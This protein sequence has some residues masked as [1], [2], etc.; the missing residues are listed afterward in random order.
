MNSSLN[1][2]GCLVIGE[3]AQAHDG[4][5]GAAHAYIDA[6]AS[7][8]AGAVKFQTHIAEAEGT[9]EEPWRVRF[10]KQDVTRRDYWRRTSFTAEQ[11]AGLKKH[12]DDRG[13]LFLSS[14]FSVEAAEM[15]YGLGMEVWKIASGELGNG[16]L[17]DYVLSTNLPVLLSSGMSDWEELD[18]AVARVQARGV[19]LTVMQCTSAYPCPPEKLGLNVLDEF[20]VRYGCP[21]GLSDHSG[22]IYAGLA[23]A[24]LGAS[25]VEVHVTFSRDCF[26]PD[27]PASVTVAELKQLTEGVRF[28]RTALDHPR[29]KNELALESAPLRSIFTKSVVVRR[30]LPAGHVLRAEDLNVKKPGTGIPASRF[31]EVVGRTLAS[32]VEVDQILS[33]ND[34]VQSVL[35]RV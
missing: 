32:P 11:W 28:I 15:L 14:P 25:V 19:P 26:G 35:E 22:N 12:A 21:V 16:P 8:G 34:L 13:L 23:A 17:F 29:E 24:T 18:R 33:E 1:Q 30:T 27:V 10:S 6:I 2:N 9:V 4:S 7:A 20:R 31:N 3:V 5:L